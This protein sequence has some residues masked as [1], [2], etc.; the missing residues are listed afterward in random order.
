VNGGESHDACVGFL[1]DLVAPGPRP[2]L[3]VITDGAPG[4]I[5]AV[6]RVYAASLR[7]RCLI[8]RVRN[9]VAKVSEVDR[10]QVKADFWAIFDLP[11][12]VEAGEIAVAE[13]RRRAEVFAAT[14]QTAYRARSPACSTI[15]QR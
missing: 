4:L 1:R 11:D 2:P 12:H 9:V 15:C 5:G 10:D 7:Q 13:A 8:H 3:L 14:W 6:E